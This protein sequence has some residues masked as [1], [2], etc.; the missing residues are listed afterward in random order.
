MTK[1]FQPIC[2]LSS[3]HADNH[4]TV[5]LFTSSS[6]LALNVSRRHTEQPKTM[7][8]DPFL[9][10]LVWMKRSPTAVVDVREGAGII[11]PSHFVKNIYFKKIQLLSVSSCT[12]IY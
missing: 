4:F 1:C 11:N 3:L 2:P 6:E 7:S 9:T 5:P 10:Q 8:Q 12:C